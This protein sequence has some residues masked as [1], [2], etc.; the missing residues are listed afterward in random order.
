MYDL[1]NVNGKL[2]GLLFDDTLNDDKPPFGGA[3]DEYIKYFEPYFNFIVFDTAYNS[4][5]SRQGRE[6]FIILQ[7]KISA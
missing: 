1:L 7:K 2:I 5:P 6:L 4:I 3:K